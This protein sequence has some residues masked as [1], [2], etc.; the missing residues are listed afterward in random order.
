MRSRSSTGFATE[1][2]N[3]DFIAGDEANPRLR[4]MTRMR[5]GRTFP[6]RSSSLRN[7]GSSV[8]SSEPDQ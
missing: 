1:S 7:R 8:S 6:R 5:T 3:G 2:R 4:G